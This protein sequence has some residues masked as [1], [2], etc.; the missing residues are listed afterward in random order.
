M[1]N[2]IRKSR[3]VN[4][5]CPND[6]FEKTGTSGEHL[7]SYFRFGLVLKIKMSGVQILK[8]TTVYKAAF[9]LCAKKELPTV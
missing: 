2:L 9:E 6:A 8:A 7:F 1:H 4:H 3:F 5:S